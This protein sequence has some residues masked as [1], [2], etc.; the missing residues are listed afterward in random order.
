MAPILTRC[1]GMNWLAAGVGA[2]GAAALLQIVSLRRP[3]AAIPRRKTAAGGCLR[4]A[5]GLLLLLLAARAART[6][7]HAFRETAQSPLAACL[8]LGAALW[9]AFCGAEAAQRCAAV[10]LRLVLGFFLI[11]A[12]FSLPQL[13]AAWLR[14][15]AEPG[16]A[17]ICAGLLLAPG[18]CAYLPP[19]ERE[20]RAGL[21]LLAPLAAAAAGVTA[22]VLSP[23]L[24]RGE[25]SF[26]TLAR[27]VSVLG[28]MRRFEALVSGAMLP[29]WFC[30]CSLLLCAAEEAFT[31]AGLRRSAVRA[32][33]GFGAL[34]FLY[35]A[36]ALKTASVAAIS[37]ISCGLFPLLLPLVEGQKY[38][39][40]SQKK[41]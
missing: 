24:A 18:A 10:L 13:R 27:S 30:L 40:K 26:L 25:M 2:A 28:V 39:R 33:T 15:A 37:A 14:P 23:A 6:G 34:A 35:P 19:R 16:N 12:V 7:A 4:M 3:A 11:V 22:G 9:A 17:M 20:K 29:A 41:C 36:G 32:L 38:F 31:A 8:L 5:A 1:T 21:W